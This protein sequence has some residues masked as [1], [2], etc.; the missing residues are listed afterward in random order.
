MTS[1]TLTCIHFNLGVFDSQNVSSITIERKTVFISNLVTAH[2]NVSIEKI[3]FLLDFHIRHVCVLLRSLWWK[4]CIEL[5]AVVNFH[6]SFILSESCHPFFHK[7]WTEFFMGNFIHFHLYL[8]KSM[9]FKFKL[10]FGN[11]LTYLSN[12]FIAFFSDQITMQFQTSQRKHGTRRNFSSF[13][14]FLFCVC[15]CDILLWKKRKREICGESD[16][17]DCEQLCSAFMLVVGC[18][19]GFEPMQSV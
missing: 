14:F 1:T 9:C 10:P 17:W 6:R 18:C 15:F 7:L 12:N 3:F 19:L 5:C 2:L 11:R 13:L 8:H 4:V 16:A